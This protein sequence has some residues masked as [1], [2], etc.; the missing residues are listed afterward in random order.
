MKKLTAS[1]F[2]VLLATVGAANAEIA[3]RAYVDGQIGELGANANVMAAISAATTAATPDASADTKG[4]MKLYSET[5]SATDGT[6]TQGAI[7]TA[8]GTK[9]DTITSTAK[10]GADLVDDSASTNKFVTAA[11]KTQIT[12]NQGDIATLNGG[13]TVA[14]SVAKTVKDAIAANNTANAATTVTHAENTAVGSATQTVYVDTD[15]SVK[16]G[17]TLGTAATENVATSIADGVTGLATS[18][19]V[20]DHVAGQ[21]SAAMDNTT[22]TLVKHTANTAA[23]SATN[24]VYIAADGTAT[25]ITSYPATNVTEDTTHRFV[26]DTEKTTWNA[27]QDAIGATLG[28]DGTYVLTANVENGVVS[29]YQWEQITREGAAQQ[30]GGE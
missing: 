17:T 9:Q 7:T 2:T 29:G 6:M 14:G 11:E 1:I 26:T 24:P 4:I 10:L 21:L 28:S 12:T 15:G 23:G 27:K 25:A 19:Q 13:D 16:A 22:G 30:G 18:D 20:Y 8:L 3:S 5:G